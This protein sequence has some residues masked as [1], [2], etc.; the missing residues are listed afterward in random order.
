MRAGQ[1]GDQECV[2]Q[3]YRV[4]YKMLCLYGDVSNSKVGLLQEFIMNKTNI[5][6]L[7]SISFMLKITYYLKFYNEIVNCNIVYLKYY[8]PGHDTGC[9]GCWREGRSRSRWHTL[10]AG[11]QP[12]GQVHCRPHKYTLVPKHIWVR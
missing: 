7:I 3:L 11:G 8:I 5:E 1:M 12:R 4:N 9:W 10:P 6:L 2:L